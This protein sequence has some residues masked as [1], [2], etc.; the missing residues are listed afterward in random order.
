MSKVGQISIDKFLET[1]ELTLEDYANG[2]DGCL[3]TA[4][5]EAGESA[6]K[7]LQQ[8]SPALTGRYRKSWTFQEKEVRRGK[9]YRTEL[10]VYNAERY[11]LTHLLE[12]SHRIA[13]KY[14]SY[15]MSKA[16]PHISIA[17]KNAETKFVK[18]FEQELGR[19]RT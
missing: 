10:V 7:E 1:M 18:V 12:K 13:N 8:T 19:I 11:R 6:E 5:N 2:V 14:G 17:Q 3:K 16:Q 9:R 15:G 4:S